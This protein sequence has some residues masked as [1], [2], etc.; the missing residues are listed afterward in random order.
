MLEQIYDGYGFKEPERFETLAMQTR[1]EYEHDKNIKVKP[2]A[3]GILLGQEDAIPS[4]L[5]VP[6]FEKHKVV[7]KGDEPRTQIAH[8][9][10]L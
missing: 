1:V 6:K 4:D 5:L 9:D 3:N 10:H 2:D 8:E 7:F